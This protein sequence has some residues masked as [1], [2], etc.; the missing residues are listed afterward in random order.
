MT[1]PTRI[2]F[3]DLDGT[4]VS[5]N[6]VTRY[7][8]FVRHLPSRIRACWKAAKLV[9]SVPAYLVLDHWSRR[10]FNEVFFG[11][12]RGLKREWLSGL[13][14]ELFERVVR[15]SI[16]PGAKELIDRDRAQGFRVVLVTGELDFVLGPLIN[17][18]GFDALICNRLVFKKEIATGEVV[19]PLI[20][21]RAKVDAMVKLGNEFGAPLA[22]CKGCSDSFSD[23]PMLEAVGS[24]AAVNPD[25]RLRKIAIERGWP[26]LDLRGSAAAK[27]GAGGQ[28]HVH[29][30]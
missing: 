11:E 22:A 8:F 21:E 14:G 27:A 16:Y 9:A 10:R 20:A 29:T 7:A 23:T 1:E 17:Y 28:Y 13:S 18:M 19:E 26:I 6:I 24:P 2:A 30:S 25:R 15:P 5:S 4:L 12:Y 3:Y